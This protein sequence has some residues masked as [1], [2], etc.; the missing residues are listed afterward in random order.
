MTVHPLLSLWILVLT[1]AT[2]FW[3]A[4]ADLREFKVRNEFVVILAALY[5]VHALCSGAWVSIQWNFAFAL[6]MLLGGLCLFTSANWRRR[7][8]TAGSRL[9]LDGPMV[10]RAIRHPLAHSYLRILCR[11]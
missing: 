11:G 3:V 4:L 7:S 8:E 1:A 6:L 9:P 10:R 2:L 5:L